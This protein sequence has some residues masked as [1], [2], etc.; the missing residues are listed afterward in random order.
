MSGC[1]IDA[2]A[3]LALIVPSQITAASRAFRAAPPSNLIAPSVFAIEVRHG[4]L[5]MERRGLVRPGS[6]DA[7]LA[8]VERGV[9][10]ASDSFDVARAMALARRKTLG[11]YDAVYLDLAIERGA[12]LASRD[13]PL[14]AAAQRRSA[15][16]FDLR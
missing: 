2:S 10:L 11:M 13:G 14:L 7:A 9:Q 4:L 6:I 1:V 16:T 15:P 8:E 3:A 12:A 5:K